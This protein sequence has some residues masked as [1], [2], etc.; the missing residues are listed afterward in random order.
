MPTIGN[1]IRMA[2][3]L[4]LIT[5]LIGYPSK[6]RPEASVKKGQSGKIAAKATSAPK[7]KIVTSGTVKQCKERGLDNKILFLVSRYCPKCK[8]VKPVIEKLVKDE[9]LE[10]Y[11]E[12]LDLTYSFDRKQLENYNIE[13]QF[14]PT[15]IVD[16][17][18]Y[19]GAK[20]PE[21]YQDIIK[22]FKYGG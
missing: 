8:K 14:V 9:E 7:I 16:C 3:I 1:L 17:R 18:V 10:L 20:E 4:T 22:T 15:L 6:T 13:V 11:Y 12:P 19:V 21:Q 2:T 5:T